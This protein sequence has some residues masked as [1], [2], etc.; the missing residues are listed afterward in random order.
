MHAFVFQIE[1]YKKSRYPLSSDLAPKA[2][3]VLELYAARLTQ[4]DR[5]RDLKQHVRLG[6]FGTQTYQRLPRF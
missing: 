4:E 3:E 1:D 2:E 5:H 6:G